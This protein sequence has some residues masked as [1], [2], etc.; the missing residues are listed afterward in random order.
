MQ[1]E[2]IL[3]PIVTL[4]WRAKFNNISKRINAKYSPKISEFLEFLVIQSNLLLKADSTL[5]AH[6]VAQGLIHLGFENLQ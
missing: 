3:R 4:S 5:N 6:Q 1:T 2:E